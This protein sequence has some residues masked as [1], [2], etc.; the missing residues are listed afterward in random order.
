MDICDHH[1]FLVYT[2]DCKNQIQRKYRC[3]FNMLSIIVIVNMTNRGVLIEKPE[4]EK[5]GRP[6]SSEDFA[7]LPRLSGRG[8]ACRRKRMYKGDYCQDDSKHSY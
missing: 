2:F 7:Y 6:I 4:E 5:G 8:G 3:K 1:A